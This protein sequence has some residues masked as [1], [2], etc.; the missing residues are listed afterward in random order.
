MSSWRK[1]GVVDA[2]P[3]DAPGIGAAVDSFKAQLGNVLELTV[4]AGGLADAEC[5]HY[6]GSM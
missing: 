1:I 5:V 4:N 2:I 6:R 3:T